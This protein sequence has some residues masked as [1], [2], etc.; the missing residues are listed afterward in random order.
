MGAPGSVRYSVEGS[1]APISIS[2]IDVDV[3]RT[4]GEGQRLEVIPR[5]GEVVP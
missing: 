3:E 5:D 4:H 2:Q 1:R